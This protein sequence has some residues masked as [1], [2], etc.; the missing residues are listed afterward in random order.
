M[1]T[2][3]AALLV[4][5]VSATLAIFSEIKHRRSSDVTLAA[6][7]ALQ[8]TDLDSALSGISNVELAAYMRGAMTSQLAQQMLNDHQVRRLMSELILVTVIEDQQPSFDVLTEMLVR[9][10]AGLLKGKVATADAEHFANGAVSLMRLFCKRFLES[11]LQVAPSA[12]LEVQ[13]LAV[14]KRTLAILQRISEQS[15]AASRSDFPAFHEQRVLFIANYRRICAEVHGSIQ[16]PDFETN[17]RIP[18]Q[19]LYVTPTILR[20][21]SHDSDSPLSA[22]DLAGSIDRT[23]I[24]GDP[25]GGKS[26]LSNYLTMTWARDSTGPLPYHV[27]L[28]EFAP[29]SETMSILQFI[30]SQI[31]AKYQIEPPEGVVADSLISGEAVVV[32]DGLDE[33]VDTTKRRS[34][35]AAVET[36]GLRYPTARI[37]VTSRRV[38]YEQ[39]RL[40]PAI[41]SAFRVDEFDRD[42]VNEYVEKW[43]ASQAAYTDD[44]AHALA[45]Q[46]MAQ[47]AAVSDLSANPLMLS[48]MCIIFRGENFIPRNRPAIYEKCATLL[49]EKWDGHR[50]IEVPL[51]ARDFVDAAMKHVAYLYLES[52]ASD[53]GIPRTDLIRE[54]TNYLFPR[55][56]ET[57]ETAQR[58][59]EEFVDFCAGRAWVFSDAGTT[60]SGEPIFTFTHRTFMEYFA[61]VHLIRI[62]DTPEKLAKAL[63]PRIAK[64]EWDVVAQLAVQQCDRSHDRGTERALS[65]MLHEQRRRSEINRSRV[66]RFVARCCEFAVV[67]P[68]LVREISSGCLAFFLSSEG[69]VG[70]RRVGDLD[71]WLALQASIPAEQAAPAA[72]AQR[73]LLST[74]L[75]SRSDPRREKAVFLLFLGLIRQFNGKIWDRS[76]R[77]GEW[78]AMFKGLA[79]SLL[80]ELD[81]DLESEPRLWGHLVMG[82][83]ITPLDGLAKM[84]EAGLSFVQIYFSSTLISGTPLISSVNAAIGVSLETGVLNDPE[85]VYPLAEAFLDDLT[86]SAGSRHFEDIESHPRQLNIYFPTGE[87]VSRGGLTARMVEFLLYSGIGLL[88]SSESGHGRRERRLRSEFSLQRGIE[89][90][91]LDQLGLSPENR[92]FVD[93]W[94]QSTA[95]FFE[96]ST[97]EYP[98]TPLS[99]QKKPH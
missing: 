2:E 48:L 75:Q 50:Q 27:T 58:A 73:D 57:R 21:G 7:R 53:S 29:A 80:T 74:V 88:E 45:S 17:Q 99:A 11:A 84:R 40:D 14:A 49:F 19:D 54:M 69:D 96:A 39:A 9:R 93:S 25:G 72:E 20:V 83:V 59:A 90:T 60:A 55:A 61:A 52:G 71:P 51:Q 28:R 85:I 82:G 30:E 10:I 94:I 34:V 70:E 78:D 32:F 86:S 37:V 56:M 47:S 8:D 92:Q 63:L 26:T 97:T 31:P 6:V 18:L 79:S 44:Q 5:S 24:L 42:D 67:S 16:P 33:L 15:E 87:A 13:H 98:A 4:E 22:D 66:L 68:A 1:V 35:T 3:I 65:T 62:S 76:A 43:F 89:E 81:S 23:V 41:F 64:E 12:V 36:F 38:G 91:D 77:S 46:F 95:D